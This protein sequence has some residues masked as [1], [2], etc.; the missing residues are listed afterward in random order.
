MAALARQIIALGALALAG[1]DASA[2]KHDILSAAALYQ[3]N[4]ATFAT[5]RAAYPGPFEDFTRIPARDPAEDNGLDR[6]FLSMLRE[7]FPVDRIDF[8]P[9][10]DS[11]GAWGGDEI[12]VVLQRYADGDHWMTVSLVYFSTPLTLS[13]DNPKVRLFDECSGEALDWLNGKSE[14]GALIAFC[15][16]TPNWYAYQKVE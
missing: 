16:L 12:D 4:A 11:N 14:P 6:D 10:E 3:E 1:C 7:H 9:I 2:G 5:I 15:Q 8:F 13:R